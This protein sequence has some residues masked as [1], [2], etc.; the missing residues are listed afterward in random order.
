LHPEDA[1]ATF[2]KFGACLSDRSGRTGYDVAYRLKMKQGNYRW[3]RA[4]GG[5]SRN[6]SGVAERACGALIDID[7]QK[8]EEDRST[9]LGY[10]A[11]VGLWDALLHQGNPTHPES[12]WTWSPEFRRLVGFQPDDVTG[13]PNTAA[14]WAD[15]LHPEDAEA[16]LNK[17]GACLADRSGRLDYDVFYRLK[18]KDGSYRWFRAMGGIKR[19]KAGNPLRACGSLIDVHDQ[20]MVEVAQK[21]GVAQRRKEIVG[22]ADSLEADVG[23]VAERATSSAQAVASAAE[24]LSSSVAE[25][26]SR[27]ANAAQFSTKAS[28]EASQANKTVQSLGIAA[29]R[30]SAVVELINS[31]AGQ[32]NLLALNATIEAARAGDAGKGFAVVAN[33]VKSLANQTAKATGDI[34]AQISSVQQE[35]K[36]ALEAIASIAKTTQNVQEASTTIAAAVEE[37]TAATREISSRVASV[38]SEIGNVH[39]AI[40]AATG[41]MR[42]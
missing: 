14:S 1:E 33:E 41:N 26:S 21:E 34:S 24:E 30:I 22:L 4:I 15:R 5:V 2:E 37:Q 17:F 6:A 27:L 16:T 10:H 42:R 7:A 38:V 39:K 35:A 9:L 11:G 32:T 29:E 28:E 12:Q 3:F 36:L 13:F 8:N 40:S 23:A 18:L 20:K 19:D 25:I 31:I